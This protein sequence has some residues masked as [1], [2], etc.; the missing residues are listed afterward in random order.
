[1]Y[2]NKN[3]EPDYNILAKHFAKETSLS[4][5]KA[6]EEWVSQSEANKKCYDRMYYLWLQSSAKQFHQKVNVDE[7][8]QKMQKKIHHHIATQQE[9][10]TD[11][12]ISIYRRTAYRFLQLAA[13]VVIGLIIRQFFVDKPNTEYKKYM[14][15]AQVEEIILPDKSIVQLSELSEVAYPEQFADDKREVKLNGEAFFKV[16]AD[17]ARP[18]IIEA[19]FAQI[20]VVGTEFTVRAFKNKDV[21]EVDVKS[22]TV[23][24]YSNKAKDKS[25][26]LHKG[27][28]GI[29]RNTEIK[30]IKQKKKNVAAKKIIFNETT[31]EDVVATLKAA[32][33]VDIK[34]KNNKLKQHKFSL[35][36]YNIGIDSVMNALREE[37]EQLIIKKISDKE[38]VIDCR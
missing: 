15:K 13:I 7:A 37:N 3:I 23:E 33:D 24:L 20:K 11:K 29:L 2:T 32:Y 17:K 9:N 4:E 16:S 22:G 27:E 31:L 30:A 35:V 25:L 19:N 36:M 14:A 8:W 21:V 10:S 26:V 5:I 34:F 28:S 6:I 18:F 12:N 1:M 38:F